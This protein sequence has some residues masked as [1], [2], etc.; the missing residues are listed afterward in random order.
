MSDLIA[1]HEEI[2]AVING[3]VVSRIDQLL[4]ETRL[5]LP[6]RPGADELPAY[7]ARGALIIDIRPAEQRARDGELPGSI[8]IDRNVLEWRLDPTSPHHI[9]EVTGPDQEIV[10]V[11]NEGY[12]SSLAAHNLQRLGLRRATDLAGGMQGILKN[13]S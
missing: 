12:Q 8:V 7:R 1:T 3:G 11:C 6:H 10:V 9:P 2:P 4:V 5:Q 13:L